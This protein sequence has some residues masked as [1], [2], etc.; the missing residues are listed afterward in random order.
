MLENIGKSRYFLP[1][2]TGSFIGEF[3]VPRFI[4]LLLAATVSFST[5][6]MVAAQSCNASLNV[7]PTKSVQ[8]DPTI[9]GFVKVG[10]FMN[11]GTAEQLRNDM[12][13]DADIL[14]TPVAGYSPEQTYQRLT[15]DLAAAEAA[16][17]ALESEIRS[18]GLDQTGCDAHAG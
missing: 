5:T 11:C 8:I 17:S 7:D 13:L 12:L 10:A 1:V 14:F 9:P 4:I 2:D 3:L 18:S 16:L 6:G 15:T